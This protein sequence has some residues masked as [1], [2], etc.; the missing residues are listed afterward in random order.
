MVEIYVDDGFGD[1]VGIEV[2]DYDCD[3]HP[4]EPDVGYPQEY[5]ELTQLRGLDKIAEGLG[6]LP[7]AKMEVMMIESSIEE[8]ETGGGW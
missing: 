2:D 1:E 8:F 4:A 3:L 6:R 5:V 7:F